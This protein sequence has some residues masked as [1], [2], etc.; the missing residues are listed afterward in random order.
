MAY[1]INAPAEEQIAEIK[2]RAEALVRDRGAAEALARVG[3]YGDLKEP[4]WQPLIAVRL[5]NGEPVLGVAALHQYD[6]RI[7]WDPYSII[8]VALA[9]RIVAGM[10]PDAQS[11]EADAFIRKRLLPLLQSH[12]ERRRIE[13]DDL[14]MIIRE[15]MAWPHREEIFRLIRDVEY[16]RKIEEEE[17]CDHDEAVVGILESLKLYG[18]TLF[19]KHGYI[20]YTNPGI[21]ILDML[22]I[23]AERRGVPADDE[24]LIRLWVNT[25]ESKIEIAE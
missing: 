8:A 25:V 9:R 16:I 13:M 24:V 18:L 22:D 21:P 7:M 6:F 14:L 15:F 11:S 2:M 20:G 17:E 19:Q 5:P 23:M 4:E 12:S 10:V 3:L 1:S